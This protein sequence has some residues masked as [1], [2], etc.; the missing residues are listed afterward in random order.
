MKKVFVI[1]TTVLMFALVLFIPFTSYAAA[2]GA[3]P[4]KY[5]SWSASTAKKIRNAA[6]KK[7]LTID[8]K[9]FTS[10]SPAI[11]DA[12]IDRPDVKITVKWTDKGS[13][14][15]F[16][17]PTGTDVEKVFDEKGYAGFTYLQNFFGEK[18]N[19]EEAKAIRTRKGEIDKAVTVQ[20]L[21]SYAGNTD[22]FN[23]YEY[24]QRYEDLRNAIGPDGDKLLEHYNT[25]GKAE[26]RT[27]K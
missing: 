10:F 24:Y 18:G 4:Q 7:K 13:A 15:S 25:N 21:K 17:I 23:A 2:A 6:A 16:V 5:S 3:S 26:G 14:K 22:E 1:F 12:M 8:A 27:A 19:T 11:R 9:Q 20:E